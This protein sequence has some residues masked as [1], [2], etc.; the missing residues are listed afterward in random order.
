MEISRARLRQNLHAV[1]AVA[2][3]GAG[4]RVETLAVIKANA[5][6]HGAALVARVLTD[7]GARWLGVSD[8][9][10]GIRVREAL[11]RSDTRLLVM[12]AM[13][14][15]DAP[16]L[17]AHELTPVVW[18]A[19]HI[20]AMERASRTAPQRSGVR[21]Q[22]SRVHLEIDTGMARQGIVPGPDLGATLERLAASPWVSCEGVMSH[23]AAAEVT[24]PELAPREE[25]ATAAADETLPGAGMTLLQR[26]RFAAALDQVAAAGIRPELVHLGNSSAVDEGATLH[27]IGAA[28]QRLGARPMVR[29]GFAL[30]GHCLPL[31]N[32]DTR[33]GAESPAGLLAPRLLPALEWKTRIVG[34]RE[35]SAGATVGYGAIF[36]ATQSMR[37]ALLPVGYAD[38]FRRAASSGSGPDWVRGWVMIAGQRAPVVG[39][40][41]MNLTT[42]DVTAIPQ[43]ALGGEVLLLG[44]GVTAEDHARWSDTIG[45]DILCGIRARVDPR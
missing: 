2:A 19:A 38:G 31:Q 28:A 29:T 43:A 22:R 23:L 39:R 1:Q 41:S 25:A 10:E 27:W 40:V 18:T 44:D 42:V 35:I 9:D 45:Y 7:S 37:V 32:P 30:Y 8:I 21:A 12:C 34:L 33:P 4:P 6:G 14:P 13:E 24:A 5:Y 26:D 3:A 20:D 15:E 17:V 16:L 36:T 11:G